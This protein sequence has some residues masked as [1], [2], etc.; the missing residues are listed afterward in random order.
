MPGL[1]WSS[2]LRR[3]IAIFV[4]G[5]L[6]LLGLAY[7]IFKPYGAFGS[8]TFVEIPR[9]TPTSQIARRLAAAGVIR[10]E[11]LFLAVRAIRPHSTVKAGEY[12][13]KE[14]ATPWAVFDRMARGDVYLISI[15]VPE[16]RNMF[17]IADHLDSLKVVSREDFLAAAR[18]P[19]LIRDLA[20]EAP[21]LEGYLFPDTYRF[22][23]RITAADLTKMMTDRFRVVWKSLGATQ[24]DVH[25]VVTLASLV[26]TEARLPE[27]RPL[28]AS[29]FANRLRAGMPLQADPTTVYAALL[30]NRYRGRIFASDLANP[31]PY[32]TYR[33]PGLPPGPVANPGVSSLKAALEPADTKYLY[34]VA[35]ADGSG[36]HR[37]SEDLAEH[38]SAVR[39]YRRA[40]AEAERNEQTGAA[41][42]VDTGAAAGANRH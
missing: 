13:F 26:E 19:S 5:L 28:V 25:R 1:R 12:R 7:Y 23:R 9:G 36:G 4:L 10:S 8:E 15:T 40:V 18:D 11:F 17:D 34:F 29:V 14:P 38:V 37:F 24:S 2:W 21:S 35:R 27:E 6:I 16:G 22:P 20:P 32:N 42:R 33:R 30:E 31:H 39:K 3:I 41:R